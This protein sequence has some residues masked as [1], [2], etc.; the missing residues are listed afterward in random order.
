VPSSLFPKVDFD[1]GKLNAE[2]LNGR[3][4]IV[5]GSSGHIEAATGPG[6]S[7]AQV[8][9]GHSPNGVLLFACEKHI[10]K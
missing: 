5:C 10:K 3:L 7:I 9:V 8:P 6:W 2:Q 4:C 1:I